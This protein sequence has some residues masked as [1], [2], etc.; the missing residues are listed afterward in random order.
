LVESYYRS[1]HV[2][3]IC[4]QDADGRRITRE[5]DCQRQKGLKRPSPAR[6]KRS[7]M[8]VSETNHDDGQDAGHDRIRLIIHYSGCGRET[9]DLGHVG[10][11]PLRWVAGKQLLPRMAQC[12]PRA[13]VPRRRWT[14]TSS[15]D[16]IQHHPSLSK[17]TQFQAACS[18]LSVTANVIHRVGK[19][20][21]QGQKV[22]G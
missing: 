8:A 11:G 5:S 4:R 21:S 22:M 6:W 15:E 18:V 7:G 9:P 2:A 3:L 10:T 13:K 16:D 19:L 17:H 1:L 20:A 14:T 12:L